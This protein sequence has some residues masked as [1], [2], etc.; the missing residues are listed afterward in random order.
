VQRGQPDG[1]GPL[2]RPFWTLWSASTLSSL[3]NGLNSVA[4]PLLAATL[5]RRPLAVA[6]VLFVARIPWLVVAI[7]AGAYADRADRPR[8]M[9]LMDL[10]RA[11]LLAGVA[12]LVAIGSMTI[13]LI[14]AFAFV[15]GVCDTFFSGSTQAVLPAIVDEASLHRANGLLSVGRTTTEQTVGPAIGGTLFALARTIP[16]AADAV[17][18]L[19]SAAFLLG[20]GGA[21]SHAVGRTKRPGLAAAA[22]GLWA[23]MK[24]GV[25]WY[26]HS[27]VL[28]LVTG[29]VAVLAF[30]QA[31]VSG[32]LV[33]FALERL[34]LHD[35]G[36]GLFMAGV[37][38]GNIIGGIIAARLL[39]RVG[40][41]TVV[42][43]ATV[44]AAVGYI[45]GGS[46]TSPYLAAALLGLEAVAVV[47]GNVATISFRQRSTPPE[48]QAR[49]ANVWRSIVWGVIPFGAL[50]GG[51]LGAHLG[52]RVPF[53]VA[54]G[55]QLVLAGLIAR[56][57][58]R[59]LP[60]NP[61]DVGS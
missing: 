54:G 52:L 10:V 51:I 29:T 23:E 14:Y 20:L 26:R 1:P 30:S 48:M 61:S 11:G 3:G 15:V 33:L 44:L 7:P 55:L 46:T 17:S 49:I 37:A 32:I 9:R 34:H 16:F 39:R 18:F 12:V 40:T 41:A 2:G 4:L 60:A 24:A 19:G 58:H 59:L 38:V 47:I 35:I 31:M 5:T 21:Q 13:D 25:A 42:I 36:Y 50:A 43:A 28:C 57:L 53:F 45:G 27:T 56:P 6:A 22:G 8:L